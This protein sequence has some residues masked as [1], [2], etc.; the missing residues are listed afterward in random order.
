MGEG[1]FPG[2]REGVEKEK[3]GCSPNRGVGGGGGGAAEGCAIQLKYRRSCCV[4]LQQ[5][6]QCLTCRQLYLSSHGSTLDPQSCTKLQRNAQQ[7]Q[8]TSDIRPLQ[9]H[10]LASTT[11][12]E[13]MAKRLF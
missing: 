13:L 2:W 12:D 4:A 11:S 5:L 7:Q 1:H 9:Y 8:R 6:R 10:C 3:G